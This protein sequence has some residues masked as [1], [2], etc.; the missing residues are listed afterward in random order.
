MNYGTVYVAS[1]AMGANDAQTVR[2]FV[3]A[4][5]YPGPSLII[6]YSHCISHGIDMAKG[7]AQQKLAVDS[8]AFILYRYDPRLAAEGKNPLQI[9][10]KPPS[11]PLSDF[12]YTE[13]RYRMLTQADPATAAQLLAAAQADVNARWQMYQYMAAAPVAGAA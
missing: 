7:L 13:N 9:D 8:G 5:S 4:E 1:V 11:I 12:I 2:A 6:A 3:E 10:S